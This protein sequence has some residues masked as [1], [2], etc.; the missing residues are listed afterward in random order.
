MAEHSLAPLSALTR[1]RTLYWL[2]QRSFEEVCLIVY[3]Q[4][5]RSNTDAHSIAE[6]RL[7]GL[8]MIPGKHIVKIETEDLDVSSHSNSSTMNSPM[9]T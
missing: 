7:V 4:P 1:K 5:S 2:I 8:I 6:K 9:Y 3:V